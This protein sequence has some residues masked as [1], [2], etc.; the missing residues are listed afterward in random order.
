MSFLPLLTISMS[1][2]P[3][4]DAGVASGFSNEVMQIGGA[5]GLAAV[6]TIATGH[7]QVLVSAGD[8][9]QSALTAS[10]DLAFVLAA[11]SVAAGLAVVLSVL[12]PGMVR[13]GPEQ[14]PAEVEEAEAA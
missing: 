6:G 9:L 1:D 2:V 14:A 10:Y 11:A 3:I 12:R 13:T 4:A 7:A 5:L 8:S